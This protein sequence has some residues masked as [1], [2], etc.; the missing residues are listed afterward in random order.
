MTDREPTT[1]R[2]VEESPEDDAAQLLSKVLRPTL[3]P[4][5]L[6]RVRGRLAASLQAPPRGLPVRWL[7]PSAVALAIGLIIGAVGGFFGGSS[8]TA[9]QRAPGPQLAER[10]AVPLP[11]PAVAPLRMLLLGPGDVR[12]EGGAIRLYAGALLLRTTEETAIVAAQQARIAVLPHST[13]EVVNTVGSSPLVAAYVGSAAVRWFEQDREVTLPAGHVAT[14]AGTTALPAARAQRVAA[15]LQ[16]KDAAAPPALPP[17]A[18]ELLAERPDE[19]L[20]SRLPPPSSPPPVLH[21]AA[22]PLPSSS[23]EPPAS[24]APPPSSSPPASAGESYQDTL[25]GES[26]LLDRAM[27]RLREAHDPYGA[28]QLLDTYRAQFPQGQLR[29]E[30]DLLRIS[31]LFGVGR[32]KEALAA[33][34]PLP[35]TEETPR[36]MELRVMRGE[37]RAAAA[38][39]AEAI[40]DFDAA[41]GQV[42]GDLLERTLYGRSRCH[43]QRGDLGAARNDLADYL[44]RFPNGRFSTAAR[45]LFLSR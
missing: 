45:R 40:A 33:L 2:W 3:S 6:G 4:A 27:S 28:L 17:L 9:R 7:L 20:P 31:A 39:C 37:L 8:W 29:P 13:V 5:Q 42:Q 30:A 38:R 1:R 24:A 32:Q 23:P 36:A 11:A 10:R 26:Q 43:Q 14:S 21:G 18:S 34:D 22:R 44:R 35:L 15:V 41:L 19:P 25:L 16:E 12:A